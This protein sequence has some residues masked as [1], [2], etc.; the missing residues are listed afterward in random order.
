MFGMKSIFCS[1][2]NSEKIKSRWYLA[3]V[4]LDMHNALMEFYWK[5][6]RKNYEYQMPAC[7]CRSLA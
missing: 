3:Y 1:P 2:S 5:L 4:L 6:V 7:I